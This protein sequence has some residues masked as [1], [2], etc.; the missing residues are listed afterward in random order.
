MNYNVSVNIFLKDHR[1]MSYCTTESVDGQSD[2][3]R[4]GIHQYLAGPNNK[5]L[6]HTVL[7]GTHDVIFNIHNS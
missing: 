6:K 4:T 1:I 3:Y 7:F 5:V 2:Y